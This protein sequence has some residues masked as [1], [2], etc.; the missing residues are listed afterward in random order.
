M[1]PPEVHTVKTEIRHQ[2]NAHIISQD[3]F[4]SS[5]N[6]ASPCTQWPS[7]MTPIASE[8]IEY[9]S[10]NVLVNQVLTISFS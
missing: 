2:D 4:K 3:P 7:G 9:G 10:S 6:S 8:A 1:K 5:T